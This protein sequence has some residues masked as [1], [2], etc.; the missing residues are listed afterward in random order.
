VFELKENEMLSKPRIVLSPDY[1]AEAGQTKGHLHDIYTTLD[2]GENSRIWVGQ[3]AADA[4][5]AWRKAEAGRVADA[6]SDL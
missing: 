3:L 1:H 5:E 2:V 4:V 6:E